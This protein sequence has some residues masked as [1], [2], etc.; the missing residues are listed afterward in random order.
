MVATKPA[1]LP[2]HVEETVQAIGKLH[3]DHHDST[4]AP[5]RVVN[6]L[7]DFLGRPLVTAGLAGA[8]AAWVGLNLAL[9]AMGNKAF[10][11][12]PFYW[13]DTIVGSA[14]LLMAA[15]ILAAQ[16][17]ASQ[18]AVSREKLMLQLALVSEQKSAKIIQ[19]LEEMR[20]DNPQIANRVDKV[21]DEMSEPSNPEAVLDAIR[22]TEGDQGTDPAAEGR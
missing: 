1:V 15:L 11:P 16:R 22:D 19:L 5:Q 20:R 13:L 4:T 17:H 2:T 8:I 12:P 6:Y 7:T 14:A 10:D 3:S 9:T 21:A 18:L